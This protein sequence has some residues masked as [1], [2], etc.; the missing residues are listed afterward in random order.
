MEALFVQLYNMS[1]L[2]TSIIFFTNLSDGEEKTNL[3]MLKELT[4]R[5]LV[6]KIAWLRMVYKIKDRF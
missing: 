6:K 2:Q 1:S 5:T 4:L 3:L